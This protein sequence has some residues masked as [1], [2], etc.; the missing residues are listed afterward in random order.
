MKEENKKAPRRIAQTVL[1]SLK[2][3]VVPRNFIP[4]VE[5]GLR[6]N[7]VKGVLAGY[8][9]GLVYRLLEHKNQYLAIICAAIVC[10]CVNTGLFLVGC[11]L[12]F[13]PNI[14]QWGQAAG[15]ENAA[16]YA[17][18]GLAGVN[19]LV[20]WVVTGIDGYGGTVEEAVGD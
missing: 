2:G 4:S 12:F 15:F 3:G 11:R 17:F 18:L 20:D 1:N 10:P 5:K 16:A 19:F 14:T 6:E 9:A 7:I 13:W 8:C